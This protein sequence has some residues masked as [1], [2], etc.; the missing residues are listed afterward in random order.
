MIST[1]ST[2]A[3]F[4]TSRGEK[5][6][7]LSLD[8]YLPVCRANAT[9]S[10]GVKLVLAAACSIQILVL[11][12]AKRSRTNSLKSMRLREKHHNMKQSDFIDAGAVEC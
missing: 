8:L 12:T 6:S 5:I 2:S 9:A 3:G 7:S 1:L 11:Y 10:L 4:N